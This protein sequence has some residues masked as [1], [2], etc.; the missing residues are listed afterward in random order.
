MKQLPQKC[1]Y[2]LFSNRKCCL[3]NRRCNLF[4]C[5]TCKDYEKRK[6]AIGELLD[7]LFKKNG[8]AKNKL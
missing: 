8:H 3:T 5:F 7:E 6:N 4:S 1:Y 2:Y